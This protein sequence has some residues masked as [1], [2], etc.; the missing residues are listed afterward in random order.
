[1]TY[2]FLK[3][4]KL[5]HD[6]S[7]IKKNESLVG[8]ITKAYRMEC[9]GTVDSTKEIL[10]FLKVYNKSKGKVKKIK[11]DAL[12]RLD[13]FV[14]IFIKIMTVNCAELLTKL[15]LVALTGIIFYTVYDI[16][17]NGDQEFTKKVFTR[18][19]NI[20]FKAHARKSKLT[21]NEKTVLN[22]KIF[23]KNAKTLIYNVLDYFGN[24]AYPRKVKADLL[25]EFILLMVFEASGDCDIITTDILDDIS[26]RDEFVNLDACL[27]SFNILGSDTIEECEE[28]E[29]ESEYESESE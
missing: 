12:E 17:I 8:P 3:L 20:I 19:Q 10:S 6:R 2:H 26:Q 27:G 15:K 29:Y 25:V 1:M 24:K 22:T 21:Y 13:K 5:L 23:E 18:F 7:K 16:A 28:S 9:I 4:P 14:N 11:R